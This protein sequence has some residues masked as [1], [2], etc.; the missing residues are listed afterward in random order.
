MVVSYSPMTLMM[1]AWA[2]IRRLLAP[3][4]MR[5]VV[6]QVETVARN[7][8]HY[9]PAVNALATLI[10]DWATVAGI[11]HGARSQCYLTQS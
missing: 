4:G 6:Q 8:Q 11:R 5:I 10:V 2:Q 1:S 3:R 7:D 9:E